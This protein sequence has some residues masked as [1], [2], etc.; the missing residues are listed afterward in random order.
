MEDPQPGAAALLEPQPM[1]APVQQPTEDNSS[2]VVMIAGLTFIVVVVIILILWFASDDKNAVGST[3]ATSS[4]ETDANQS[5]DTSYNSD[6]DVVSNVVI[7]SVVAAPAPA[8]APVVDS[9]STVAEADGDVSVGPTTTLSPTAVAPSIGTPVSMPTAFD[10]TQMRQGSFGRPWIG[11]QADVADAGACYNVCAD[12]PDCTMFTHSADGV[13]RLYG[14]DVGD[15]SATNESVQWYTAPVEGRTNV[16]TAKYGTVSKWNESKMTPGTIVN[17]PVIATAPGRF[18]SWCMNQCATNPG[19]TVFEYNTTTKTCYLK[20][21]PAGG[22]YKVEPSSDTLFYLKPVR[23]DGTFDQ[24]YADTVADVKK[25][26][27]KLS[28]GIARAL[29]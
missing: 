1:A 9:D 11:H 16:A 3:T 12:K 23:G 13:C 22:V 26:T 17:A 8:P 14:D 2:N 6:V 18:N 10:Q 19:C 4:A 21:K 7:G 5:V 27:V 15:Y 28:K 20:G 25:A 29:K 24:T